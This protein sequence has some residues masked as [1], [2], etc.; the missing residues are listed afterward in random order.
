[1]SQTQTMKAVVYQ[2]TSP[3]LHLSTIP[4][5]IRSCSPNGPK[6]VDG[7]VEASTNKVGRTLQGICRGTTIP[8][9]RASR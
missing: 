1:M 2:G 4:V 7:I 5:S 9:A 6:A 3:P 8:Q